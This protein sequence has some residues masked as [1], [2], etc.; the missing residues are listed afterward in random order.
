MYVFYNSNHINITSLAQTIDSDSFL[1]EIYLY[2]FFFWIFSYKRTFFLFIIFIFQCNNLSRMCVVVLPFILN[3]CCIGYYFVLFSI[4]AI[5]W[6]SIKQS[7][8]HR[9]NMVLHT[10]LFD[11][12]IKQF[13]WKIY[14]W[15]FSF[16]SKPK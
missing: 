12:S 9:G 11:R 13:N 15:I 16:N 5:Y 10:P 3:V 14:V 2:I 6:N 8:R 4:H 7:L 1:Q